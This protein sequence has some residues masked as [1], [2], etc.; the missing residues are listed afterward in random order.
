[1]AARGSISAD[2]TLRLWVLAGGRCEYCNRYLL[3]DAYTAYPLNLAERAHIVGATTASGSPRGNHRLPVGERD[4]PDNLM[5]LCREHHR[6]ID[7][8]IEEHSV[9]FLRHLKRSHE[10]RVR[11]QTSL[12]DNRETLVLRMVGAIRG[13][14]VS[15]PQEAVF[16]A[17]RSQEMFPRLGFAMAGEDLEID[18][19]QLPEDEEPHYWDIGLRIIAERTSRLREASTSIHHLSIFALARIPFLVA[20]GFHLDDK[21]PMTVFQR[22]RDG[23]GSESWT[24]SSDASPSPTF[25]ATRIADGPDNDVALAISAT[26]GIGSEVATE[27]DRTVYELGPVDQPPSRNI[28][29]SRDSLT[30]FTEAYHEVLGQIETDHPRC[31]TIHLFVAAPASASIQLGRGI[32]RDSQPA[33]A[34]YDRH[35]NGSFCR[36]FTLTRG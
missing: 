13:A 11:H 19:R 5:L 23:S 22:Q 16:S 9:D 27:G 17:V 3:E 18:L 12:G 26:A 29:K 10:E 6:L 36:A 24:P 7:R 34:V 2:S 30:S 21:I 25:E 33:L 31:K 1:M 32:M 4:D 14:P 8:L 35:Q 28:L 15:I 20:L